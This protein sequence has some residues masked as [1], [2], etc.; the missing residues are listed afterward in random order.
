MEDKKR[1]YPPYRFEIE[2][3]LNKKENEHFLS[4]IIS[5]YKKD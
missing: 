1:L 5:Y 4:D 3:I 2:M